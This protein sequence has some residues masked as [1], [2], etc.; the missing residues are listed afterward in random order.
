MPRAWQALAALAALAARV[1][2]ADVRVPI[3]MPPYSDRSR[4]AYLCVSVAVPE[5]ARNI[6]RIEPHATAEVVHHML[7]FGAPGCH[8]R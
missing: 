8:P 7:L 5:G 4:D 1:L 3:R 2:A 6:I